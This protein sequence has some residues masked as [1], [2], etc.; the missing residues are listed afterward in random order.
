M[1]EGGIMRIRI[2]ELQNKVLWIEFPS[3]M[4]HEF[5]HLV[6]EKWE[7]AGYQVIWAQVQC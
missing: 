7:Q 6:T 1:D 5:C 2:Q 3:D 4:M